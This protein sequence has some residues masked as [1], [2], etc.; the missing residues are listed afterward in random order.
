[1]LK[2]Y[3]ISLQIVFVLLAMP[4]IQA[5]RAANG[6]G[7]IAYLAYTDGYWQVW[8]VDAK[9][10]HAQPITHSPYDKIRASWFPDGQQLLV[11][12][13]QGNLVK[14]VLKVKQEMPIKFRLKGIYDAVI[15]PDGQWI[16]ASINTTDGVDSSEIWLA[17]ANG[18]DLKRLTRRKGLKFDLGW[19][20]DSA[21]IYFTSGEGGQTHDLWRITRSGKK[22]KQLTVGQR[23]NFD[24]AVSRS[25]RL[26]FSSNRSG[27]YEIWVQ[28]GNKK[29]RQVTRHA[30]LD[31]NPT[32]SPDGKA[33]VF[34]STRNGVP[35]LWKLS[36]L[37]N[38]TPVQL[39]HHK[40]GA[41][42]PMWR[43]TLRK[44]P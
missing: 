37:K 29:A 35:N 23:Y 44:A 7:E 4:V 19:S 5:A 15:S 30:A 12:G 27:N 8:T 14:V 17:K 28:K 3:L 10:N 11:L 16:A 13:S 1:M 24:V 41:R 20:P 34:E 22:A 36:R 2:K 42:A 32:W 40:K 31:G 18:A 6:T 39:T 21:F 43:Q 26:A 25:H 33:L 9:G 38:G